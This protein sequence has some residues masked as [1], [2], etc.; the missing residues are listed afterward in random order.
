MGWEVWFRNRSTWRG[1]IQYPRWYPLWG[2]PEAGRRVWPCKVELISERYTNYNLEK[3]E[4]IIVP[5]GVT[6]DE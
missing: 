6:P 1:E 5:A 2:S 3:W 4:Y